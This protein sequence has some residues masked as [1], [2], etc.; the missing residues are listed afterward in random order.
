MSALAS[1]LAVQAPPPISSREFA[2]RMTALASDVEDADAA[3]ALALAPAIPATVRV[4]QGTETIDVSLAWLR[5][6]LS[7]A[8]G[9]ADEWA[10]RRADHAARLRAMGREAGASAQGPAAT[11]GDARAALERVLAD[12]AFRR[13]REQSWQAQI[14]ERIKEWLAGLWDRTLGRR[15]GQRTLAVV[16]AWVASIGAIVV[17][18]V[19]LARLT[20]RRRAEAAVDMGS[21]T[22]RRAAARVLALE[23]ASLA[24][25]GRIREA[26]RVAYRAAVHRL[27]EE[28]AL[29]VDETRTPREYLRQLPSPH[30]RREAF[31]ALTAAFERIWYGSRAADPAEGPRIV[32]LL[33][34]LECLSR[35]RAN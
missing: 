28:G 27:D 2:G 21:M 19:W 8:R 30:R 13:A 15:V 17:L 9:N 5:T 35:D 31:A 12:R 23:A 32:A 16:L 3:R 26:A 6:A 18:L 10:K 29:K 4:T 34:D 33:Q 14:G 22:P 11:T 24:G 7:A 1:S 20:A 25:A